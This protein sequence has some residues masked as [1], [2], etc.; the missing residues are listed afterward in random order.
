MRLF[1]TSKSRPFPNFLPYFYYP[2]ADASARG[3]PSASVSKSGANLLLRGR[4]TNQEPENPLASALFRQQQASAQL[5]HSE[6][7]T[8]G[9]QEEEV[10]WM[11]VVLGQQEEE[12]SWII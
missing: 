12:V 1:Q 7:E 6:L 9:R 4:T 10:S 2:Q 5:E 11:C 3:P 8:R